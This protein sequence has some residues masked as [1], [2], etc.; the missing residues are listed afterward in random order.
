MSKKL[1][2]KTIDSIIK[3][4]SEGHTLPEIYK[5]MGIGYGTVFRYAKGVKILPQYEE[6]WLRK[7]KG[8]IKRMFEAETKAQ[9]DA[10]KEIKAIDKRDKLIIVSSLYWAEGNKKDFSFT[11]TD[12]EMIK[13]FTNSLESI[14]IS[15]NRLKVTIRIYEDLD[16]KKCVSFWAETIKIPETQILNVNVVKGKKAGKLS[17]GMCRI[18][19]TKGGD[20]LK[21][22]VALRKRM[23]NLVIK[24][25]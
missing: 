1:P 5:K 12:P 6:S 22:L 9:M 10:E 17:Y 11:N 16:R 4:R 15:K 7:R 23:T 24:S 20:M 3:L 19:L 14:G 2:Q 8:S 18:R 21:Y 13:L 25:S